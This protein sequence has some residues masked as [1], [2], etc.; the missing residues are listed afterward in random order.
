[1]GRVSDF[2]SRFLS[3]LEQFAFKAREK[4]LEAGARV[5]KP[6]KFEKWTEGPEDRMMQILALF[7]VPFFIVV[8]LVIIVAVN[9]TMSGL[10][11]I[12]EYDDNAQQGIVGWFITGVTSGFFLLNAWLWFQYV[13]TYGFGIFRW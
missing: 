5:L 9:E 13:R 4:A 10:F 2:S 8:S 11:G 1:M 12:S 6:K 3:S 7:T